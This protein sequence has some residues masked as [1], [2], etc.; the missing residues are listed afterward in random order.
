MHFVY[1]KIA[2]NTQKFFQRWY[3]FRYLGIKVT[4]FLSY[5]YIITILQ[6]RL[7]STRPLH[8]TQFFTPCPKH[9][10][11]QFQKPKK[12][13]S[14]GQGLIMECQNI[15]MYL[16]LGRSTISYINIKPFWNCL[17]WHPFIISKPLKNQFT[18][19]KNS[20]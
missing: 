13:T 16:V 12:D 9:H 11:I 18:A 17:N 10:Q 1:S 6:C 2:F 4:M 8:S 7:H 15:Y 3:M 14:H 5:I 19:N 20:A